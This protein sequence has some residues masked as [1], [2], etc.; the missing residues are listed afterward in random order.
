MNTRKKSKHDKTPQT[1]LDSEE[2]DAQEVIPSTHAGDTASSNSVKENT[3]QILLL[4]TQMNQK[5]DQVTSRIE[6]IE[7]KTAEMEEKVSN[8]EFELQSTKEELIKQKERQDKK[9]DELEQVIDDLQGRLR[10]KTL[11]FKG[12]EENLEGNDSWQNCE[13]MIQN[14]IKE[15][16]DINEVDIERAHRS[17]AKKTALAKS[18]RIVYVAFL[19][20]K[21]KDTVM[22]A[23][24]KKRGINLTYNGVEKK[25]YIE[26]FLA[27]KVMQKRSQLLEVRRRLKQEKPERK[28]FFR[29]PAKLMIK[30]GSKLTEYFPDKDT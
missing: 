14:L 15:N 23:F 19:R 27:P 24:I 26:E 3:D 11:V 16:F 17:P 9:I 5:L 12:I 28:I 1:P 21:D 6:Q 2:S 13:R 18:S 25:I 29:Y 10:R 4:V 8:N 22:K 30:E 20:W 7:K